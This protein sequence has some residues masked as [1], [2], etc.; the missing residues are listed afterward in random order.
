[1]TR[2]PWRLLAAA[3]VLVAAV[4]VLVL[5]VATQSSGGDGSTKKATPTAAAEASPFS[6]GTVIEAVSYYATK[7]GLGGKTYSMTTPPNCNAFV[8]PEDAKRLKP[9]GKVC[10][11]FNSASFN[12][13]SGAISVRLYGKDRAWKLTFELADDGWRVAKDT[14]TTTSG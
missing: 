5:F 1:M 11:D 4:A 9:E 7:V 14:P 10:I 3:V 2:L 13:K 6:G 8:N 12:E